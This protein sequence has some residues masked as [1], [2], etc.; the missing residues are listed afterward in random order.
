MFRIF[1]AR[2]YIQR[3]QPAILPVDLNKFYIME[4]NQT[5][6]RLQML[7]CA[8]EHPHFQAIKVDFSLSKC[9]DTTIHADRAFTQNEYEPESKKILDAIYSEMF[10]IAEKCAFENICQKV[11]DDLGDEALYFY[12]SFRLIETDE[13]KINFLKNAYGSDFVATLEMDSETPSTKGPSC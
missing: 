8:H 2:Y 7:C 1:N 6:V 10:Q 4:R 3:I 5:A 13:E 11:Q 9:W 12:K